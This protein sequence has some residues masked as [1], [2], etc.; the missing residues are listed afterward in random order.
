MSEKFKVTYM[1]NGSRVYPDGSPAPE[2]APAATPEPA[3]AP[4]PA[5]ESAAVAPETA[6]AVE[7][8]ETTQSDA[9]ARFMK[10]TKEQLVSAAKSKGMDVPASATKSEIVDLILSA[11]TEA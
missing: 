9:V 6:E 4:E 7:G 5:E 2:P 3:E 10:L 11:D 1:V 8:P